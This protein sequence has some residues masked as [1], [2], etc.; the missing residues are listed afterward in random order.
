[1]MQASINY[2]AF[3]WLLRIDAWLVVLVLFIMMI[4][5]IW[6]GTKLGKRI[7]AA[8]KA[9]ENPSNSTLYG[10]LF[11]LLAFLLGF[12]FS[13][14]GT[15]YEARRQASIAEANA[16]GTALLRAD[17]YPDSIRVILRSEF[18]GYLLARIENIMA[19]TNIDQVNDADKRADRYSRLLWTEATR[20]AAQQPNVII[21][22][23]MIP[24]LNAMFDSASNTKYSELMRVPQSIVIMLFILSITSAFFVGYNSVGKGRFDW[25]IAVGF[26]ILISTVIFITLDL[27]RPRRG[28]IKLETSQQSMI[29]LMPQ[30]DKKQ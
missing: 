10:S 20:F 26:C 19:G 5:A 27:D 3:P 1:M 13:M 4:V 23:Q 24:A 25:T 18:K 16:I 28:L 21:S 30:F 8:D 22:G 14:S 12:T 29:D 2:Y 17:L 11:G 15:R 6:L 9:E 7:Q